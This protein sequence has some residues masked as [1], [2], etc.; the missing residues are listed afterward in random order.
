[1]MMLKPPVARRYSSWSSMGNG[2]GKFS[3]LVHA[4][5]SYSRIIILLYYYTHT[6]MQSC[7]IRLIYFVVIY[8]LGGRRGARTK[9]ACGTKY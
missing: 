3:R 9:I 8:T 2:G 5:R 4:T 7:F 6:A 1:M